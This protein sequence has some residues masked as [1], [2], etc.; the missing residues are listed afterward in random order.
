MAKQTSLFTFRGSVGNVSGY[1]VNTAASGRAKKA[2]RMKPTSVSNPR[3]R[4]QAAQRSKVKPA[5]LFYQA[6][7]NVL[8]HAFFPK[9][10]AVKNKNRFLKLAMENEVPNVA[11]GEVKIPFVPYVVSEGNLGLDYLTN[12]TIHNDSIVSYFNIGVFDVTDGSASIGEFSQALLENNPLLKDGFEITILAVGRAQNSSNSIVSNIYS[13][14]IDT[15]NTITKLED[16]GINN[17]NSS[18]SLLLN[19]D[20]IG[21]VNKI[22]IDFGA[23]I[24]AVAVII[25]S[26]TTTSWRYTNSKMCLS[27]L[28]QTLLTPAIQRAVIESY[29]DESVTNTSNLILQQADNQEDNFKPYIESQEVQLAD[30]VTG[31]VDAPAAIAVMDAYGTR[32]VVVDNS[33]H[34]LAYTSA[35]PHV[36]PTACMVTIGSTEDELLLSQTAWANA[37]SILLTDITSLL[38]E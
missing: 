36:G 22:A 3:T 29:M 12:F 31:T 16:I 1:S 17:P 4:K 24:Y 32:A 15:N 34:V 13:F 7:E 21:G 5:Q 37:E 27:P 8:N 2:V 19:V 9:D 14:V 25:S 11:K 23:A 18:K 26:K 38:N 6:F 10:K 30:G 20:E 33:G 35:E 28:G